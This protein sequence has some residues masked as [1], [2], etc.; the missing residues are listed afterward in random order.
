M[1]PFHTS[2]VFE[3]TGRQYILDIYVYR[4]GFLWGEMSNQDVI[5]LTFEYESVEFFEQ[6]D[7]PSE[8]QE[9]QLKSTWCHRELNPGLLSGKP[10]LYLLPTFTLLIWRYAIPKLMNHTL[11]NVNILQ[12]GFHDKLIPAINVN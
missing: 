9:H 8:P 3:L 4:Y 1:E 11:L 5:S 2:R 12:F 10:T 6:L 7:V